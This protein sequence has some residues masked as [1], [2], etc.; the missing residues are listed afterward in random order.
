MRLSDVYPVM[1]LRI[2]ERDTRCPVNGLALLV[3]HGVCLLPGT[4]EQSVEWPRVC[5]MTQPV[6][7]LMRLPTVKEVRGIALQTRG[8]ALTVNLARTMAKPSA[9]GRR[10]CH[11]CKA[12]VR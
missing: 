9:S 1:L 8:T 6:P 3:V 7:R 2:T 10:V 5:C 12:S 4:A 11:R